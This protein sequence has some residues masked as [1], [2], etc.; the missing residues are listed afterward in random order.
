MS[1]V[2]HGRNL[3]QCYYRPEC[4]VCLLRSLVQVIKLR[5]RLR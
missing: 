5:R 2:Y 4:L 1:R 3:K